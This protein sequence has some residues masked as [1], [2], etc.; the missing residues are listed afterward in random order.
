[1][2]RS[3]CIPRSRLVMSSQVFWSLAIRLYLPHSRSSLPRRSTVPA[4]RSLLPP[5]RAPLAPAGV[6]PVLVCSVTTHSSHGRL[7]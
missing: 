3:S 4:R 2:S 6:Q 5:R 7:A 1:M